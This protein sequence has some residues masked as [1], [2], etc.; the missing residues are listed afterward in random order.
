MSK[1][2]FQVVPLFDVF[3][4]PPE[5]SAKYI[6]ALLFGLT[7]KSAIRPDVVAGP[8]SLN[9]NALVLA[10]VQEGASSLIFSGCIQIM[11]W[12][13]QIEASKTFA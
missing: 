11:L 1:I 6:S 13:R 9:L 4:T 10:L 8:M 3:Q 7:A 2:A 12:S 5:A